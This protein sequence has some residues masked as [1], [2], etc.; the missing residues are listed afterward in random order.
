M[1][2]VILALMLALLALLVVVRTRALSRQT[3]PTPS[4][5]P[6]AAETLPPTPSPTP[7]PTPRPTPTPT[8]TP[9]PTPTPSPTPT[10]WPLLAPKLSD[11]RI[12]RSYF[13]PASERG[14]L[15]TETYTAPDY[16]TGMQ[17]PVTKTMQVYL[18]YEYDEGRPY[19][20][21][22]LFPPRSSSDRFWLEQQHSY[23]VAGG[24]EALVSVVNIL[25]NLIEQELCKP[26]LVV[27][28]NGYLD[29]QAM[30]RHNSEQIYPQME[31]EFAEVI[32]PFVVERF[33]TYAEGGSREQLCAA[34][35]HFGVLGASF[36][37]YMVEL[38]ILAPNLDLVSWYA[39]TGG[40]SVSRDYL[41]PIWI[42]CGTAELPVSLLCFL[43]GENDDMG[44]VANSYW[45]LTTW[46]PVFTADANLKLIQLNGTAHNETEWLTA[47][48]DTVQLFFRE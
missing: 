19:D 38:S 39:M 30:N 40:G 31:R 28:L 35:E 5:T 12:D 14:T 9:I 43:E 15:H 17:E 32:L 16:V 1:K 45:A 8:P 37:A 36:G 13:E 22:F 7:R 44:P 11:F 25:D 20:V 18:P 47:F 29:E 33:P 4:P 23:A 46:K 6:F 24:G 3:P 48:F 2:R 41:E 26:M 34:R 42:R 27:S 21:L 10:P